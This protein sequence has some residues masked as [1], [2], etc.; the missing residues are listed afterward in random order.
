MLRGRHPPPHSGGP[1][2]PYSC[3]RPGHHIVARHH[4][5]RRDDARG[6]GARGIS[7]ALPAVGLGRTRPLGPVVH[8]R[9]RLP[10]GDREGGAGGRRHRRHRHHQPARDDA[11]LGPRHR[12]AHPQRHRLAG[13]PHRR[14][15]PRPRR[16]R[17]DGDGK[18]RAAAR[19]LFL[20]HESQ[21]DPRPCRRRPRPCRG[22]RAG[23]RHRRHLADLE[24]DR[25]GRPCHRCHQR[26]PHHA[27]RHPQGPVEQHD[28]RSARHPHGD[29]ARGEGLRRRFRHGPRRSVRARNP[30]P[31]R[32]GR[33][34]G[35]HPGAGLLHPRHAEIDLWHGMLRAAQ[36]RRRARR[37]DLAP[38]DDHRLPA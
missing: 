23:L 24:A 35:G 28:L 16:S 30:D 17:R 1:H 12:P 4:L 21:V 8:H 15:L 18:D 19:P 34:A 13:P 2:D 33:P 11:G 36:H 27:L 32:R 6:H 37:L 31:R 3:H 14:D 7:P 9:R 5:R 10:R 29:A 25:W 38:S 20:G 22:R 26:L